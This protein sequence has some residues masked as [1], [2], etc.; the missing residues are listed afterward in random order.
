M[1]RCVPTLALIALMLSGPLLAAEPPALAFAPTLGKHEDRVVY[2][3]SLI[4][5]VEG[6]A[7]TYS[8]VGNSVDSGLTGEQAARFLGRAL[9]RAGGW[10]CSWSGTKLTI[11]GWTDPKT[12]KFH[13]TKRIRFE[14]PNLPKGYFPIITPNKV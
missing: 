5:T 14:S 2:T 1:S 7:H 12:K 9:D 3:L 11:E 13:P 8:S 10:K 6:S 4:V